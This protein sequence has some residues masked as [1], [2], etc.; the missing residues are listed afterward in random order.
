MYPEP[1][2]RLDAAFE[3]P[4]VLVLGDGLASSRLMAVTRGTLTDAS[5]IGMSPLGRALSS[6]I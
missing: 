5:F 2:N 6:F 1:G 4:L 3:L